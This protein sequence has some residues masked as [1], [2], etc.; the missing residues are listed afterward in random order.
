LNITIFREDP[1]PDVEDNDSGTSN[2]DESAEGG[3]RAEGG[4]PLPP[5][6]PQVIEAEGSRPLPPAL[7][8]K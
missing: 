3:P 7:P 2:G 6:P 4:H 5:M 8:P 1:V